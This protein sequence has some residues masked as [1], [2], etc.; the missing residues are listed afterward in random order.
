MTKVMVGISCAQ[1]SGFDKE[2]LNSLYDDAIQRGFQIAAAH[3]GGS[4]VPL[5]PINPFDD[6]FAA[7]NSYAPPSPVSMA[8]MQKEAFL[9]QMRLRL[10]RM[11]GSNNPFGNP[12]E[13]SPGSPESSTSPPPPLTLPPQL[14]NPPEYHQTNPFGHP[15]LL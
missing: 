11:A 6:M 14:K 7:S 2:L 15:S 1:A 5:G 3:R 13:P 4:P 12:F 8:V 9:M 10:T